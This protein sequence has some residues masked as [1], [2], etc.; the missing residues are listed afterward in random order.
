MA[1]LVL[2]VWSL[3]FGLSLATAQESSGRK[4]ILRRTGFL[5]PQLARAGDGTVYLLWAK[6]N[7]DGF[8][9]F[10]SVREE[11]SHLGAARR[12]NELPGS[13]NYSAIDELRPALSAGPK[14]R[15]AVGW[16]DDQADIRVA[17]FDP[18]RGKF[19]RWR[20]NTPG[21]N[22]VRGFVSLDFDER[23]SLVAVWLDARAAE[24]GEEEPAQ[25]YAVQ[26]K[27]PRARAK[28]HNLTAEWTESVCG[29]CRPFVRARRD[30]IE[31]LVRNVGEDG[32][33][34]IH[35]GVGTI[36]NGLELFE[37][38]GPPTW[39]I[40][41]C[42]MS[43]AVSDGN[44]IWW[45]DGST[46]VSRIVEASAGA[47]VLRKVIRETS[48]W[49]MTASPRFVAGN[50]AGR[51]LLLVPGSPYG[52][53]LQRRSGQWSELSSELPAWCK[54]AIVLGDEL[55]LAGDDHSELKLESFSLAP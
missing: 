32:Y 9:L 33:R 36:E 51:P 16:L 41:A 49:T 15:A 17:I 24:V 11:G 37:R 23:G 48:D 29:C 46:G 54:S 38:V 19:D 28:E 8:D 6:A 26:L 3:G 35:R 50:S 27:G 53:I 52:R 22:A 39:K 31:V 30:G 1:L 47:T 45:R 25:L 55:L 12:V 20:L 2:A 40:E 44:L 7:G 14:G 10:L 21:G 34:D 4:K 18:A 5:G 13:V 43:G 42:P